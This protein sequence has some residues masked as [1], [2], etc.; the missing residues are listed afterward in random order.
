MNQALVKHNFSYYLS[1]MSFVVSLL[2]NLKRPQFVQLIVLM[3]LGCSIQVQA[4]ILNAQTQLSDKKQSVMRICY[5]DKNNFPFVT[6]FDPLNHNPNSIGQLGTLA[7]LII[8]AAEK[9]NLSVNM[10]RQ[11]WKRCIQSLKQGQV[12]AI[13][14]AIWT[15]ERES[16][17]VFPKL[18][19]AIDSDQRLWRA[20]YP[21]FTQKDS[22][23]TWSNGHFSG[24]HLGVSA[25]LGYIAY[26][27]L[28]KLGVLP[29]NNLSAEEGFT[30]LA[31]GRIDG[32]VIEQYIGK[33]IIKKLRLSQQLSSLPEDFMQMDWFMPVSHQWYQ[34]HPELTAKFWQEMS[35]VRKLQ[36]EAIFNSYMNQ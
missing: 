26:D 23:L 20:K 9:I 22:N 35:E 8:I 10:V 4:E 16:W 24:L 27:K 31:R 34:Q 25:P 2:L 28:N 3:G 7:D 5:E 17:G 15:A 12:D 14:A 6:K 19:G 11:P 13:F 32:Y 18:N 21:I 29:S 1:L 33:N 36:G 30:L